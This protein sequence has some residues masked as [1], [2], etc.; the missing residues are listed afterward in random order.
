MKSAITAIRSQDQEIKTAT[1]AYIDDI[2]IDKSRVSAARVRQ[3]FADYG[4]V[5]KD[6]ERLRD[7]AK[8]LGLQ[9]WGENDS[10]WWKWGSNV[11]EIN[12]IVNHQ[13]I[14]TLC[15][16]LVGHF[17]VCSWLRVAT[18][19]I[20]HQTSVPT[21][22]W[23]NEVRDASLCHM[24]METTARVWEL[25]PVGEDWCVDSN[26]MKVWVD[27]SSV[28]TKMA[29][30]VNGSIVEEACWLRPINDPRHINLAELDAVIKGVNLALQW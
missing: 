10:P 25:D 27:A 5:S 2:F 21:K 16:K 4:L 9:V 20:K 26:E 7:G 22:N 3:Y 24:L 8:V 6:P 11:P 29:V 28:A 17:P 19:F 18:A 13:Y 30:G 12:R 23:D 14:L 1:S 15:G